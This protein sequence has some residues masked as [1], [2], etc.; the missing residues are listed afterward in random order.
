MKAINLDFGFTRPR[1]HEHY[2]AHHDM[3]D[4]ITIDFATEFEIPQLRE[5]Y[6]QLF[7]IENNCYLR[8]TAFP[9]TPEL[10][11]FDRRRNNYFLYNSQNI[12]TS[13]LSPFEEVVESGTRLFYELTPYIEAPRLNYASN[14]AMIRDFIEKMREPANAAD[15]EVLNLTASLEALD[16]ANKEFNRLY[17][18]RSTEL[19][20][21]ST[22]EKMKDIR[23]QVDDAFKELG[24]TINA[25]YKINELITKDAKKGEKLETVIDKVNAILF[26]LQ[27]TLSRAGVSPKP[28]VNPDNKPGTEKPDEGGDDN[29]RPV[30]E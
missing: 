20:T 30:I 29:D 11:I 12:R 13:L 7:N 9:D 10:Q 8:N 5:K 3:L 17:L 14:T 28:T 22:S 18:D 27:V 15:M 21:R 4:I 19:F 23:P 16:K 1:N 6:Q 25:L 26:Q 2:Q 24:S